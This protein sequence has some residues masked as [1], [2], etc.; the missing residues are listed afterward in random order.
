MVKQMTG[1]EGH[2]T[3]S[4]KKITVPHPTLSDPYVFRNHEHLAASLE[5]YASIQGRA[6]CAKIGE[7]V[8]GD[9]GDGDRYDAILRANTA[10]DTCM[11]E[12]RHRHRLSYR[13]LDGYY[14]RGMHE[15]ADGWM[16]AMHSAGMMH[17]PRTTRERRLLSDVFE[18]LL[19][20]ATHALL[21]AQIR[22]AT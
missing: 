11:S 22:L 4:D 2:P 19:V 12:L 6:K 17:Q 1:G 8:G 15:E 14:R 7:S 21:H 18:E 13:L 5:Q 16:R 9:D 10:I 20:E 3:L